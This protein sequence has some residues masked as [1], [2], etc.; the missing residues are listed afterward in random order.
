MYEKIKIEAGIGE[1]DEI[2]IEGLAVSGN[3]IFLLH[4]GNVSGNLVVSTDKDQLLDYILDLDSEVPAIFVY[5]FQLPEY[6][7]T[8][9]G[10]SGACMLPGDRGILFTASLEET[11][12]VYDDGNVA[13]SYIGV[14]PL[15][16]IMQG[17]YNAALVMKNGEVLAK[18]LEGIAVKSAQ[19]NKIDVFVVS[20]NDDGTSDLFEFR[21][22]IPEDCNF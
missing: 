21:I 15:D 1:D 4:R 9:S 20:D 14:I 17:S 11:S 8:K 19:D 6:N 16:G 13:G 5:R 3:K 12:S 7:G 2:N 22:K 18:K 10:F